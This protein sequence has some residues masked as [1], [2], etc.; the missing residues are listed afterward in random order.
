M[1]I[2]EL[3]KD[4]QQKLNDGVDPKTE[5]M[6]WNKNDGRIHEIQGQLDET[7]VH[8]L[9][10]GDYMYSDYPEHDS[11]KPNKVIVL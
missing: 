4:L 11:D 1:N 9:G 8:Y 10:Y 7:Y 5:V 6:I 2:Q 3:M